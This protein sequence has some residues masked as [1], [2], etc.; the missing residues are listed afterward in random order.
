MEKQDLPRDIEVITII[1]IPYDDP[2]FKNPYLQQLFRYFH[3]TIQARKTLYDYKALL[4]VVQSFGRGIRD[5]RQRTLIILADKRYTNDK[6]IQL[7]PQWLKM[8]IS[9]FRGIDDI[10]MLDNFIARWI[11]GLE[12]ITWLDEQK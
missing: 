2:L 10:Q 3:S 7:F 1:G 4:K 12:D 11:L 9:R 5:I 8:N 6:W